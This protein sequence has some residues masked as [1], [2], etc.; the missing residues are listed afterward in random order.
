MTFPTKQ[1]TL[2]ASNPN[3]ETI[4]PSLK[5][6]LEEV[7]NES[8]LIQLIVL[9]EAGKRNSAIEFFAANYI[10]V[11]TEVTPVFMIE[12]TKEMVLLIQKESFIKLMDMPSTYKLM[13]GIK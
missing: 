4:S 13:K 12:A 2:A 8:E 9:V 10:K 3:K 6:K 1:T 7:K 5:L 11:I